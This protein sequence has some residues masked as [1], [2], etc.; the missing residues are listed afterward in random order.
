MTFVC[1]IVQIT[2]DH[3]HETNYRK[4]DR[5]LII[6]DTNEHIPYN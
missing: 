4:S 3:L 6:G 2:K 5:T 1:P